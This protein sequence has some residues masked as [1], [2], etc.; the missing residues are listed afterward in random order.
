MIKIA[1]RSSSQFAVAC[2]KGRMSIEI[3]IPRLP[4][5][6]ANR[7]NRANCPRHTGKTTQVRSQPNLYFRQNKSAASKSAS[8]DPSRKIASGRSRK[9]R[10]VRSACNDAYALGKVARRH[11]AANKAKIGFFCM[12]CVIPRNMTPNSIFETTLAYQNIQHALEI[13]PKL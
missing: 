3:P 1:I 4:L 2:T 12:D 10:G 9:T 5:P 6:F 8:K 11:K 7:N 13:H